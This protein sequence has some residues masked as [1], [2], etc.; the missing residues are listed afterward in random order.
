MY[1]IDILHEYHGF[2]DLTWLPLDSYWILLQGM[3]SDSG[4]L[5]YYLPGY[6]PY[7][8]GTLVGVDGQCVG[9]QPY[10]SS[11]GYIQHPVS[12][13]S[14]AMP[15]YSWD[16]TYV[17]DTQNG[18]AV[19]TGNNIKYGGSTGFAKSNSLNNIKT[20]GSITSKFSKSSY[21]QPT[22]PLSKVVIYLKLFLQHIIFLMLHDIP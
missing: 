21:A 20:N 11:S 5:L 8:A 22:K 4:S 1:H 15:C 13:S 16:S 7:A 2:S 9:Q 14:E 19:G 12:Y 6:D 3:Q 17:A 10:Y 18:N